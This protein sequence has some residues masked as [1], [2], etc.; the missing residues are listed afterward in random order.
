MSYIDFQQLSD[1]A[2]SENMEGAPK[3]MNYTELDWDLVRDSQKVAAVKALNKYGRRLFISRFLQRPME[4]MGEKV[5][6]VLNGTDSNDT[7]KYYMHS[8]HDT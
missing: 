8:A 6:R 7:L 4:A 2:N 1:V 3:R 5:E